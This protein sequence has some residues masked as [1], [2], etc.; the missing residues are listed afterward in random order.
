MFDRTITELQK[1]AASNEEIEQL[2]DLV[3]EREDIER[4][5]STTYS[6][7]KD[8]TT[9]ES[10][11]LIPLS[12]KKSGSLSFKSGRRKESMATI[13]NSS[14]EDDSDDDNEVEEGELKGKGSMEIESFSDDEA[15]NIVQTQVKILDEGDNQRDLPTGGGSMR[16]RPLS[17]R[18]TK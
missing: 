18:S 3:R 7:G 9:Q 2:G 6:L 14:L 8:T 10:K 11:S 15:L 16:R 13:S 12:D 1:K 17:L 4:K 5:L